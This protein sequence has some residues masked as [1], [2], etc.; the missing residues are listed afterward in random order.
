MLVSYHNVCQLVFIPRAQLTPALVLSSYEH[1]LSYG[2]T[3]ITEARGPHDRVRPFGQHG[4]QLGNRKRGGF[5][6]LSRCFIMFPLTRFVVV[7]LSCAALEGAH[8]C[9]YL[10]PPNSLA[11]PSEPVV[12]LVR[13][14]PPDPRIPKACERKCSHLHPDEAN[15][16]II[17][18][19]CTDDCTLHPHKYDLAAYLLA[20]QI[21]HPDD[22]HAHTPAPY[23]AS[24]GRGVSPTPP[25]S[26]AELDAE[27]L[28]WCRERVRSRTF[29][30]TVASCLNTKRKDW[31]TERRCRGPPLPSDPN[32]HLK[33]V[34][35]EFVDWC[36]KCSVMGSQVRSKTAL[37]YISNPGLV[38]VWKREVKDQALSPKVVRI[39]APP[40][41]S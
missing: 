14:E 15:E 41:N 11:Y 5:R 35:P 9:L 29:K 20:V 32:E 4:G 28:A 1:I 23:V 38:A 13:R 30:T 40:P 24:P 39:I 22:I 21:T 3:V 19:S 27:F 18:I 12:P 37:E 17:R 7:A 25:P 34:Y 26:A 2:I 8:A 10:D 33:E 6:K 36:I 16:A 31:E